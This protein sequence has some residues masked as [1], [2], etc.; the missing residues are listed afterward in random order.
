MYLVGGLATFLNKYDFVNW[1]D[2][3]PNIWEKMFQTTNQWSMMRWVY[4][5][6]R[7]DNDSS[8]FYH[9]RMVYINQLITGTIVAQMHIRTN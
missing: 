8:F 5:V 6:Y 2:D 3:I 7:C 4:N 1:D 9:R